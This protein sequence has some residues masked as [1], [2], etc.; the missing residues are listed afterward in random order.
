ML[1]RDRAPRPFYS[2]TT[3]LVK[4]L[5]GAAVLP[6]DRGP[7]RAL[8]PESSAG[9]LK[10]RQAGGGIAAP[11]KTAPGR[12]GRVPRI[13]REGSRAALAMAAARAT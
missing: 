1:A 9:W 6:T 4:C 5:E 12:P 10:F 8:P 7:V 3:K 2:R 13:S 11:R